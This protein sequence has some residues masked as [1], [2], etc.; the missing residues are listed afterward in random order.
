MTQPQEPLFAKTFEFA[1]PNIFGIL[2]IATDHQRDFMNIDGTGTLNVYTTDYVAT[3]AHTY[4]YDSTT[5]VFT[6]DD[7]H[8]TYY[9][10]GK[11]SLN[12]YPSSVD[13]IR[14]IYAKLRPVEIRFA[15]RKF[16]DASKVYLRFG[17]A[18]QIIQA[19]SVEVDA[20]LRTFDGAWNVSNGTT[21]TAAGV[22]TVPEQRFLAYTVPED[23]NENVAIA[24]VNG[25]RSY[26]LT[27]LPLATD[28]ETGA[29]F[30][31]GMT[32][33]G[34]VFDYTIIAKL[35]EQGQQ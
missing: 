21:V 33:E 4:S 18:K 35:S 9:M 7:V 29:S 30:E 3:S 16:Y 23:V 22:E 28:T 10:V 5:G 13:D 19:G 2:K 17:I 31:V 34:R 26:L 27:E 14:D 25:L 8:G 20:S 32:N 11:S 6:E 24:R 12:Y 15:D 1:S